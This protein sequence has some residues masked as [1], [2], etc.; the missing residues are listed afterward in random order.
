[1]KRLL[2][3]LLPAAL[4]LVAGCGDDGGATTVPG[5]E[6]PEPVV[7][8]SAEELVDQLN[9]L[10]WE[11]LGAY[12]SGVLPITA[13]L[14]VTGTIALDASALP[15]PN[16]CRQQS[17]C[18]PVAGLVLGSEVTGA[19]GEGDANLVCGDSYARI[20]LTDTTVRL[21]AYLRDT[22]PCTF[23]ATPMVQVL[24]ACGTAC[25]E[26][27]R[28]C[29][30]D[31]VCYAAGTAY[32]QSCEGGSKESCACQGSEGPLEE[33]ASCTYWESGDVRCDGTCRAGVCDAGTCP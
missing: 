15:V 18:S 31:G 12:S 9:N 26:G 17:D 20:L 13:D 32:C 8:A 16:D 25:G 10:V 14:V 30:V 3:L 11:G 23:N 24:P 29:P 21:R 19:V 28:M 22:H 6:C 7:V 2:A 4:L 5:L 33:G 1:M 27:Q